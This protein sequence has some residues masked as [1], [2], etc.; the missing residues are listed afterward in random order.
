MSN[1]LKQSFP[2]AIFAGT[3]LE[4]L[5]LEAAVNHDGLKIVSQETDILAFS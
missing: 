1:F 5:S 3:K 2:A 4:L